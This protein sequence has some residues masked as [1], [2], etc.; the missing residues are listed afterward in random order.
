VLGANINL[1]QVILQYKQLED[2]L[3]EVNTKLK[4]KWNRQKYNGEH[5]LR[6]MINT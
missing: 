6:Q 4:D 3:T 1:K 2:H 5:K